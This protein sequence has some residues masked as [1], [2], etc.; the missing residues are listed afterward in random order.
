M[1]KTGQMIFKHL[2]NNLS[3]LVELIIKDLDFEE[4]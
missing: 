4:E 1:R 2:V 3:N